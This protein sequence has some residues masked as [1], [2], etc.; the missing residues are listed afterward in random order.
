MRGERVGRRGFRTGGYTAG[1]RYV[2][3]GVLLRLKLVRPSRCNSPVICGLVSA[4]PC[5][6]SSFFV[7]GLPKICLQPSIAAP[8]AQSYVQFS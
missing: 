8:E 5:F 6:C 4:M 1:E 2:Y 7:L 3:S